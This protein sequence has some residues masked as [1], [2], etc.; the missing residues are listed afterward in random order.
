MTA[1]ANEHLLGN[2]CHEMTIEANRVPVSQDMDQRL[3]ALIQEAPRQ[4]TPR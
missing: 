2:A 4:E 3:L 1:P